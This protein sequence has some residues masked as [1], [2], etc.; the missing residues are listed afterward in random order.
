M[1]IAESSDTAFSV[2][3]TNGV[4]FVPALSGLNHPYADDSA[5]GTLLGLKR[6]TTK[7]QIVRAMLESIAFR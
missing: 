3:D 7:E 4:Y 2:A 1:I 5:R 6:E